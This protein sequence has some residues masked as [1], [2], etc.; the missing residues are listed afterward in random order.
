DFR[1]AARHA[2]STVQSL[3]AKVA[4]AF[5]DK[6]ILLGETGWP[7]AGRMREGALPSPANQ[8]RVMHDVLNVARRQ[9]YHANLI[10]AFDQLWKR[11]ARGTRGGPSGQAG[12]A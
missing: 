4:A 8:A 5:P 7:G 1:R 2:A 11:R 12:G 10:E 9:G 3:R 6:E